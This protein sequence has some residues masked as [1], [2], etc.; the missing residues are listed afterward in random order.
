M[1][2]KSAILHGWK[3]VDVVPGGFVV[4]LTQNVS[5]A[6]Q[7]RI[8]G[9]QLKD[10][11]LILG[12]GGSFEFGLLFRKPLEGTVVESILSRGVGALNIE[13]ARVRADMS[14]FFS[15]SGRPRSGMGHAKGFGMGEGYGGDRAN[16]PHAGGRWPSNLV[17]IHGP[18]CQVVGSRKVSTGV[19]H[20]TRSG[21]KTF[22][23]NVD[24]PPLA[25]MTYAGEDGKETIPSYRCQPNC[26]VYILNNQSGERPSTLTGRANPHVSHE[27]PSS[28]VTD[29]WFSGGSA[30]A[31]Q[32]Y[33]D[34]GS[35]SRFFPQFVDRA[36]L[37]QW[38]RSL[39]GGQDSVFEG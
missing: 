33:A 14:E 23:G 34:S 22:G 8:F 38:L 12:P 29:S 1:T 24:K 27:H 10:T 30:K 2:Y 31:S 13:G 35:A 39:I 37:L 11:F 16:P 5:H 3:E 36:G 21:G 7:A 15:S 28:A 18:N 9:L 4:L 6:L 25:N 19:A 32:V 17:F 26:S 20:R